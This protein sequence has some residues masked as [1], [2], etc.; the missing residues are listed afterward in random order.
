MSDF[1]KISYYDL[2]HEARNQRLP[3]VF[4]FEKEISR[5]TRVLSRGLQ[6]NAIISA[7]SGTGKTA[8]LMAWASQTAKDPAF[9]HKKIIL[10][11]AGSLQKIG[12]L[13]QSSL[14]SYQDAFYSL[15]NCILIIDSFGEM[16][17]QSLTA[18]QNWNTL[19]KPLFFKDDINIVL[20]MQP[21]ELE[22]IQTNKSHFLSH[23]EVTK[24]ETQSIESQ[25][26]ILK[27]AITALG[28]K[29]KFEDNLIEHILKL[30]KRF[31]VL[32]QLPKSAIQLLDEAATD[33]RT[34]RSG[35]ITKISVE[36]IVSE[37]TGVPL[38]RLSGDDKAMLRNLPQILNSK[39]VGQ[40]PALSKMISVI[41]RARLGLRNQTKPL[42]SFLLLG[43]SGVGKTE[44]AKILAQ[45]LYG[46]E[47]NWRPIARNFE[48]H[49]RFTEEISGEVQSPLSTAGR[50]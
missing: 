43:P 5:L 21:E 41:Q 15:N 2:K 6:H 23:F 4:G 12:Q 20:S 13:P 39:I 38:E 34:S 26:E 27:Q 7:P 28:S 33:A 47:K 24:L 44:T 42:G 3:T 9:M 37:K 46:S 32:G 48:R 40:E 29:F 19:I 14:P 36:K 49:S 35:L 1:S 16:V 30:C 18:L 22:W 25:G 17:Y 8:L 45:T 11:N 10:L 31:P 50:S